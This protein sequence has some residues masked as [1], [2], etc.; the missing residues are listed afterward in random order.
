[1]LWN[2]KAGNQ[3]KYFNST[4]IKIQNQ[5]TSQINKPYLFFVLLVMLVLPLLSDAIE[6]YVSKEQSSL[7]NLVGK[8]FI[9]SAVGLRLFIAGL[10]QTLNPSFTAESIFHIKDKESFVIVKELGFANICMGTAG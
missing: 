2:T 4:I 5:P 1:M 8:W 3:N 9:F 7:M 6:H 10:R